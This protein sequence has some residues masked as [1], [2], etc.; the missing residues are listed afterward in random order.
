MNVRSIPTHYAGHL[1]RSR[2]EARWAVFLDTLGVKW[3]YESQG[4]EIT[5]NDG[6][7]VRYL[8]DYFIAEWDVYLE[9]KGPP[10]NEAE[11]HKAQSLA[12]AT[13]KAVWLLAGEPGRGYFICYIFTPFEPVKVDKEFKWPLT[14]A[15]QEILSK[16]YL[17][18]RQSR[19]EHGQT[20]PPENWDKEKSNTPAEAEEILALRVQH[21]DQQEAP[22]SDDDFWARAKVINP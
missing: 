1:M 15:Q 18:A 17:A 22:M 20:G 2:V 6:Q 16:A 4:L 21:R 10:P 13:E 11:R 14:E 7:I 5:G 12:D 3:T 9:I 19:F 8:P